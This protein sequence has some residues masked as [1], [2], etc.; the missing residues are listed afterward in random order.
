VKNLIVDEVARAFDAQADFKPHITFP[1]IRWKWSLEIDAFPREP[2]TIR[3]QGGAEYA[4]ASAVQPD[5]SVDHGGAE[6]V[7]VVL[8]G[9]RDVTAE[10]EPP[11]KVRMEE[12]LPVHAPAQSNFGVVDEVIANQVTL[13]KGP[14]GLAKPEVQHQVEAAHAA[15]K[16]KVAARGPLEGQASFSVRR[17]DR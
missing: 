2:S 15:Q 8:E 10:G 3:M 14:R 12:G 13:D 4:E 17:G 11:D 7:K 9:E 16:Q 1:E 5:D 6:K